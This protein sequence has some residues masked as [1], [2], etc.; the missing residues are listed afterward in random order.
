MAGT[1]ARPKHELPPALR[2]LCQCPQAVATRDRT[3]T[4]R[5][6]A[7]CA[8]AVAPTRRC[9]ATLPPPAGPPRA[10]P[11]P[12]GVAPLV[13]GLR[14]RRPDAA[15][16][17][18]AGEYGWHCGALQSRRRIA[19]PP[20]NGRRGPAGQRFEATPPRRSPSMSRRTVW[21]ALW[22]APQYKANSPPRNGRRGPAGQRFEATP[23]RRSPGIGR[24]R[25]WLALWSAPQ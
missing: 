1:K 13:S 15:Q 10:P 14:S 20:R 19:L 4:H 5:Y 22:S 11:L 9:P 3:R 8:N 25:V 6:G 2:R 17:S 16:A 12:G 7:I 24:W 18:A 23:P 21:L